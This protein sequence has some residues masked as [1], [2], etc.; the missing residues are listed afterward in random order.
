MVAEAEA[1]EAGS[2]ASESAA[3]EGDVSN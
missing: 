2:N 1:K 3:A